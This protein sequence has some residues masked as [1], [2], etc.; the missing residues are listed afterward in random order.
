MARTFIRQAVQIAQSITYTDT[1][2]VGATMESA[3][4]NIED[5]LNSLRSQIKRAIYDDG[6]GKWYDDIPTVNSKK[7]GIFDLNTDLNDIEEKKI[8]CRANILTDITV[9]AAQNWE[10]LSVAGAETPTQV[11]AVSPTQ[12]GAVVAQSALSAGAFNVHELIETAGPDALNPKNLVVVRSASTGQVIQSSGRDVFGLLQYESTGTNG[13]AF[14]DT[15]G[16]ARAK[17]SF[18]RPN[19]GFNDLEAVPVGDIATLTINYNY[20][21]RINFD[22]F[23]EDASLANRNFV[24]Q[25]ASV[26]VNRQNAYTNQG[27]TAVELGT[28]ATLDLNS[29]GITW[30]LRDLAN[31]SL[32]T[33]IEGSGGGTSQFNIHADVDELDIDA[34]VVDFASGATVRSGGTR[35]IAIGT[36]DGVI[37][38]T[39]GDLRI[40][41][42]GELYLDD[43]NQAGST[44]AQ[45]D[46]IKFSDTTAEWNTFESNYGEVSLL[47]AINQAFGGGG[48]ITRRK[49][50]AVATADVAANSNVAGPSSSN[51]LDANLGDLSA[52]SFE[53]GYDIYLNGVLLRNGANAAANHDVYPGSSLVNGQIMFEFAIRGTGATPDQITLIDWT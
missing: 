15:S 2:T 37:N 4:S 16:G 45:T 33:I 35:P 27:T 49:V 38:S 19:A 46:G 29:A 34:V 13:G 11:A 3:P 6:A 42:T 50:V 22:A 12:N 5:D 25:S 40:L 43:G 44:W 1:V 8:L 39:A 48:G 47:N 52:G 23:P 32:F 17:I 18:V 41:G 51:N 10:L 26:D 53:T 21:F 7:R 24:D 30:A 28:S 36:T 20:V 14:N 9:T 31:A